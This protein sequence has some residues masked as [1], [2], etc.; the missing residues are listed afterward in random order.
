MLAVQSSAGDI[1]QHKNLLLVN[2]RNGREGDPIARD[3]RLRRD[4]PWQPLVS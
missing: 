1:R 4:A 2:P 3:R